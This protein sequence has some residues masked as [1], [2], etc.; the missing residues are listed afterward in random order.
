MPSRARIAFA[1]AAVYVIWGSTYLGIKVAIETLPPLLMAGVRFVLAGGLLYVFAWG[2]GAAPPDRTM[3]GPAA[4]IGGLM[5]LVGNGGV[6]LAQRTVPSSMAA[7][8]IASVPLWMAVLEG[9][10]NGTGLPRGGRLVALIIGFFAVALLV[11]PGGFGGGPLGMVLLLLAALSWAVGSLYSRTATRPRSML[12]GTAMQML[13]GGALQLLVGTLLG[14]WSGVHP[15]RFSG[16][17]LLAFGYLVIFGSLVGFTAYAWLLQV[18]SPTLAATYAYV[19]PV[20]AVLLGW[21]IAGEPL[22]PRT[23][24]AAAGIIASVVLITMSPARAPAATP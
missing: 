14:E 10:K 8:V 22:G 19:N 9:V 1:L 20:V 6:V 5:L 13:C 12:L 23:L 17:S 11:G 24:L 4:L 15:E 18:V 21:L 7:L 2:R 3:W 16:A